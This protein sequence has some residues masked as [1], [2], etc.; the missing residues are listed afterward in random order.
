MKIHVFV[1]ALVMVAVLTTGLGGCRGRP[2]LAVATPQRTDVFAEVKSPS[3]PPEG[4]VDLTIKASVKTPVPGFYLFGWK[5]PSEKGF[6]FEL[7]VDGQEITWRVK[8]TRE[9]TPV[10]GPSGKLPEGGEG[11]RYT[12]EKTIRLPAGPHHVVFGVPFEDYYT[13]V[14]IS[15]EQ[16]KHHT[17][18]F[19]PVYAM[20]WRAY[21][22]FIEGISRTA[23]Y[24]DG[25]RIK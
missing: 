25:V 24:L 12:L 9:D 8:G 7:N 10:S 11:I 23:V 19:E 17:L 22:T 14:K 2:K 3:Q 18:A 21:P 13:E 6:P 15:L 5:Q 16:G 1:I 4:M 20:G